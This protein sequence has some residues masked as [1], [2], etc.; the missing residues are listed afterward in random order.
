MYDIMHNGL[1]RIRMTRPHTS[2]DAQNVRIETDII[3]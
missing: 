3:T 1:L 2:A